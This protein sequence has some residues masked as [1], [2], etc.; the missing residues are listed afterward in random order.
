MWDGRKGRQHSADCVCVCGWGGGGEEEEETERGKETIDIPLVSLIPSLHSVAFTAESC[1]NGDWE[2]D[3][4]T[5][6]PGTPEASPLSV[7]HTVQ[8]WRERERERERD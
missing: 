8:C 4:D 5:P 1:L 3:G 7:R 2:W 6:S